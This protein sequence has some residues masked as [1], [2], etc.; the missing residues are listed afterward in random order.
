MYKS[1]LDLHPGE[2]LLKGSHA[3][4]DL[5][6]AVNGIRERGGKV[7]DADGTELVVQLDDIGA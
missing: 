2:D 3:L 4:T 5:N 7:T 6:N 1:H